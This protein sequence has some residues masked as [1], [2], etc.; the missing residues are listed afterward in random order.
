MRVPLELLHP[1]VESVPVG[2]DQVRKLL[3]THSLCAWVAARAQLW[4]SLCSLRALPCLLQVGLQLLPVCSI[5]HSNLLCRPQLS[6]SRLQLCLYLRHVG[7]WAC[8]Q[9]QSSTLDGDQ[10]HVRRRTHH[11]SSV[12]QLLP[13]PLHL[14]LQRH[15]VTCSHVQRLL[16][17]CAGKICRHHSATELLVASHKHSAAYSQT[18]PAACRGG[19]HG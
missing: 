15:L 5:P 10:Q 14:E 8:V 16:Q 4:T 11:S 17:L 19:H 13:V 12:L 7:W 1:A 6:N 9:R 2:T 18:I 3:H